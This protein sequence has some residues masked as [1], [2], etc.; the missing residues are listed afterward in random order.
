MRLWSSLSASNVSTCVSVEHVLWACLG[1]AWHKSSQMVWSIWNGFTK[2]LEAFRSTEKCAVLPLLAS[3]LPFL[4]ALIN[5]FLLFLCVAKTDDRSQY[6]RHV[7]VQMKR[8]SLVQFTDM[9]E[10]KFDPL[11]LLDLFRSI[12]GVNHPLPAEIPFGAAGDTFGGGGAKTN[13]VAQVAVTQQAAAA[14]A[15]AAPKPVSAFGSAPAGNGFREGAAKPN[16]FA[17]GKPLAA[18]AAGNANAF[19]GGAPKA[20]PFGFD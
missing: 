11:S 18:P 14:N 16:P 4:T 5:A 20:N 7:L 12:E 1:I 6:L 3:S 8:A 15:F 2:Q 10:E 13:P 19:G 9:L 17:G